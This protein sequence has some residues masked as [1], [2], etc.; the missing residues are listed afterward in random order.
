MLL[1]FA[2]LMILATL[3]LDNLIAFLRNSRVILG[4]PYIFLLFSKAC[5]TSVLI[6]SFSILLIDGLLIAHL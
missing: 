5:K 6:N 2:F 3:G 1:S 4:L